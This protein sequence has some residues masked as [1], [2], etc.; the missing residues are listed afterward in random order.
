MNDE[1][2][3]KMME[4]EDDA[5]IG[6][7]EDNEAYPRVVQEWIE[8]AGEVSTKNEVPCAMAFMCLLGTICSDM[9]A[10]KFKRNVEDCRIHFCWIQTTGSGKSTLFN[11]LGPVVKDVYKRIN[12]LESMVDKYDVVDVKD[13]TTP[14]LI[15]SVKEMGK[16]EEG[17]MEYEDNPGLLLG[18]GL[19]AFDEFENVG[20]F[21]AHTHKEGLVG[22]LNT[23]MNT[24]W[25]Q[26]YVIN[27]K[28]TN[29]PMIYCDAR[30][31]VYATTYPPKN[32]QEVIADTGLLQRMVLFVRET[33]DAEKDQMMMNLIDAIGVDDN[34]DQPIEKFS[35]AF[36]KIYTTLKERNLEL[37]QDNPNMSERDIALSMVDFE[38]QVRDVMK[39][40]YYNMVD[41]LRGVRPE[42]KETTEKFT[43]RLFVNLTKMSVLMSISEAP[44]ITDKSKRYVVS[45]RNVRQASKLIR[46]CYKA[47]VSWLDI[48]L[49]ER[50]QSIVETAGI[51]HWKNA[52]EESKKDNEG[53][54]H[55]TE[56]IIKFMSLTSSSRPTAFRKF[57]K[58]SA[59]FDEKKIQKSPYVKWKVSD[60]EV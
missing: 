19:V 28:L 4:E 3:E 50:R 48:A 22:H 41:Y 20:V 30:R 32:L 27:K 8:S 21:K 25:G 45:R 53:F 51:N 5:L 56:L 12:A 6:D 40:E 9:V 7:D 16:N 55:K 60:N 2:F 15:G 58:I 38:P 35:N 11:F 33:D 43:A 17:E 59:L 26:N 44:S 39:Y 57:K 36:F 1:E 13:F 24:L 42:V 31:S 52:F 23:M 34:I 18:S 46:Q 37:I 14:A 47:L 29:G 49:R 10:V 54:V